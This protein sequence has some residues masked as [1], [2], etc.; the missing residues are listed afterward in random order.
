[1]SHF[2]IECSFEVTPKIPGTDILL[3]QLSEH[4]FESFEETE[5][6]LNGYIRKEDWDKGLLEDV[7]ILKDPSFQI[8]K[9]IREIPPENWNK[10]WET[11]FDPIEIGSK[12][13]VRAPFH[14]KKKVQYDI[15]IE[16]KMSF[17]TG[18]HETTYMMLQFLLDMELKEKTVLDMGCGTAVLA[19]LAAM[20][21]AYSVDGID[22]DHWSYLNAIENAERNGQ[23]DITILEGDARVIPEKK[24]DCILANI[25]RNILLED[26]GIYSDHLEAKGCL[27]LSGFYLEDEPTIKAACKKAGLSFNKKVTRNTWVAAQFFKN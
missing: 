5:K 4:P 15:V 1:M 11:H 13:M 9:Q 17:G 14:K 10:K 18:H 6:G 21:G 24:Y 3:A 7:S 19:I 23:G 16:P 25:N 8:K 22:I 2:Y 20:K 12:C 27:L 26:I